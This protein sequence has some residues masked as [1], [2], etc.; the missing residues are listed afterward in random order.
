MTSTLK[1]PTITLHRGF[2]SKGVYVY[3]PF[4]NKLEARFRFAGLS[5]LTDC[6][7]VLKAPKGKVP[8]IGISNPDEPHTPPKFLGDSTLIIAKLV[9]DGVIKDMNVRLTPAEQAHDLALR[10]LL[11]EKLNFYQVSLFPLHSSLFLDCFVK[12]L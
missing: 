5:Y 2:E 8:Y 11:E 9:E 10:A 12:F 1:N 4:V 3:S 7:S 6:G